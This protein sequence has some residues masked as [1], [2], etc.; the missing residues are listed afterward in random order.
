M[1]HLTL[2]KIKPFLGGNIAIL[3]NSIARGDFILISFYLQGSLMKLNPVEAGIYLIPVS[4]ALA[5]FGPISGWLSD[6]YGSRFFSGFSL[7]LSGVGFLLLTQLQSKS[8]FY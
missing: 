1:F 3:F 6:R 4:A 7:F 2:F 8:F 5:V